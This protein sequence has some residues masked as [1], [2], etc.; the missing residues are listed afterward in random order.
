MTPKPSQIKDWYV[1]LPDNPRCTSEED[2][3]QESLEGDCTDCVFHKPLIL[4][5]YL[6]VNPDS[7]TCSLND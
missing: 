1:Y 6:S 2:P 7:S 4:R 3:C 5:L